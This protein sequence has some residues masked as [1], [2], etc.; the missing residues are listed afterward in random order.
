MKGTFLK[1]LLNA[2]LIYGIYGVNTTVPLSKQ[3]MHAQTCSRP[4]NT[5]GSYSM[6]PFK[7]FAN[8]KKDMAL[9]KER[10]EWLNGR[11]VEKLCQQFTI[12]LC[13]RPSQCI[14][15]QVLK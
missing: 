15:T 1:A 2:G 14:H 9:T 6:L 13:S 12:P 4:Q 11:Q 7:A 10:I 5:Q 3:L 8:I